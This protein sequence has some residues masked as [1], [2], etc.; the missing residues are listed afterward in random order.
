MTQKLSVLSFFTNSITLHTVSQTNTQINKNASTDLDST[1][2]WIGLE[3]SERFCI[4]NSDYDLT[5]LKI[6]CQTEQ[7]YSRSYHWPTAEEGGK[8][9][10]IPKNIRL[11][12]S[13]HLRPPSGNNT[14][15]FSRD[16]T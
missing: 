11:S 10:R 15:S 6:L 14:D 7:Y 1:I 8:C 13:H 5:V 2:T 16:P 3:A 12:V 9:I 4:G